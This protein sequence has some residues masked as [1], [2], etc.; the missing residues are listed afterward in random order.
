MH[1]LHIVTL[2]YPCGTGHHVLM[3]ADQLTRRGHQVTVLCPA[4]GWLKTQLEARGIAY[5]GLAQRPAG[6]AR[7]I[8]VLARQARRERVQI[9]HTHTTRATYLGL[10]LGYVTRVPVVATL[11]SLTHDVVYRRLMPRKANRILTVSDALR[12]TLLQQKV[13]AQYVQTV[14]NGTDFLESAAG[15]DRSQA[16]Q[17]LRE[18]LRLPDDAPLVGLVGAVGEEK[19]HPLLVQAVPAILAECPRTHFVFA[20]HIHA[21]AHARLLQT[22]ARLGIAD[23]LHF[24]GVR[25]DM[26]RLL[27]AFDVLTIPSEWETFGMVAIE[28]MAVGTPVVAARVG[29]LAEIIAQGHCGI[30]VERE[31]VVLAQAVVSL[32]H[33][34][35]RRA[36]LGE[37]GQCRVEE[38]FGA[39]TMADNMEAVYR[40]VLQGGHVMR[41]DAAREGRG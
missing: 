31:P 10:L 40:D 27:A 41:A 5:I 18:E 34:P 28:A 32:L 37:A 3:A 21:H 30:L 11:H 4:Q 14:Y 8:L 33:D 6:R 29:G 35:P 13:P 9:V 26:P 19:G 39:T 2:S 12:Q 22:A 7:Q 16:A 17:S 25:H 15:L 1:I 24:L 20:G 36:R 23:R 38:R